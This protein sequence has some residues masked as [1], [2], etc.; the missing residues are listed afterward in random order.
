MEIFPAVLW[1]R[2]APH[3]S[4]GSASRV[5]DSAISGRFLPFLPYLAVGAVMEAGGGG[6]SEQRSGV[7]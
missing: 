3:H 5:L 6:L 1:K 7:L 2:T 4:A